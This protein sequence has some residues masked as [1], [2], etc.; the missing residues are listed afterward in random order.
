MANLNDVRQK[1]RKSPKWA[2]L[3]EM[4]RETDHPAPTNGVVNG[5][6]LVN[7]RLA[8]LVDTNV[9]VERARSDF[10]AEANSD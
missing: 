1:I 10:A 2:F 8:C 3:A 5:C 4:L 7:P 9:F 6:L